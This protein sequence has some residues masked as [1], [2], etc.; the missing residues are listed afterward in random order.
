MQYIDEAALQA[1]VV[2]AVKKRWPE[3]WV[4]HPVGGPFQEAG[5]PDL[6]MCV[7]GRFV[8][9]ELKHQK[10]HET[11]EAARLRT[12]PRQRAQIRRIRKAGGSAGT[13]LTV[14]EALDI[15]ERGLSRENQE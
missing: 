7:E 12:T 2:K 1:A 4:F 5:V 3:A 14:Q 13:A 10:R 9:I 11:E 6:L 8:G 15:I